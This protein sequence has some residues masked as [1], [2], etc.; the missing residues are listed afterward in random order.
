MAA[1]I[2]FRVFFQAFKDATG[3][4]L[5]MTGG[6]IDITARKSA[7]EALRGLA[8]ARGMERFRL[9]FE[10]APV[11]MALI[12]SDGVWLGVNHALWK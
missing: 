10:E 11:G 7:E 8:E 12:G 4:P 5:R 2:G 3:K 9:S 1:C 6:N